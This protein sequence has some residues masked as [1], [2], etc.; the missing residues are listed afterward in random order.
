MEEIG[1]FELFIIMLIVFV[2]LGV[3]ACFIAW[4]CNFFDMIVGKRPNGHF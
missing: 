3:V 1:I 4:V 2:V